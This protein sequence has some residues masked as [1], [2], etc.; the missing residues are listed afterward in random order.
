M[1]EREQLLIDRTRRLSGS[2][3]AQRLGTALGKI[4]SA[5]EAGERVEPSPA[6]QEM[7]RGYTIQVQDGGHSLWCDT[8]QEVF[9]G[10]D[11]VVELGEGMVGDTVIVTVAEMTRDKRAGLG[12]FMGF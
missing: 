5:I 1:T 3:S 6:G 9:D 11:Q 10:L 4:D 8:L 7:V 2:A 12:E